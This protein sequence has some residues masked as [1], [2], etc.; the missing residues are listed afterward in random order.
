MLTYDWTKKG[1]QVTLPSESRGH[2]SFVSFLS[3]PLVFLMVL[4]S[5]LLPLF[6]FPDAWFHH[7]CVR[8]D[9]A[10]GRNWALGPNR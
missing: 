9:P 3:I 10:I 6:S 1:G 2:F 8:A 4:N 7:L 5:F